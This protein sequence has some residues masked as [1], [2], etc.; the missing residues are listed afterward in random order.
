MLRDLFQKQYDFELDQRNALA[1]AVNVPIVA[2]T[3]LSTAASAALLDFPYKF[4]I[5]SGLFIAF[6]LPALALLGFA[7]YSAMRSFWGYNYQKLPDPP[8]LKAHLAEL[9]RW[10][11]AN[12]T[13]AAEVAAA[14]GRDFQ[15]YIDDRL[16]EAVES[17][18]TNNI[19]RGNYLH[20]ATAAVGMALAVFVPAAATYAYAK[21]TAD[22]KV[23]QVQLVPKSG[24]HKE[25]TVAT[26][27]APASAPSSPASSP[28]AAPPTVSVAKPSGPPNTVFRSGET[29][30]ASNASSGSGKK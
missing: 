28:P 2:I 20:R 1:S 29:L 6:A 17:N 5:L 15:E 4:N 25:S 22:D 18:G 7:I 11:V 14:A 10:H 13:P 24:S 16:A 30:P 19:A 21:A 8:A 9:S 12:G 3:V 23:H 26:T 27:P